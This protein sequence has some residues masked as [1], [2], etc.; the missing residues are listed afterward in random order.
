MDIYFI[1]RER[2]GV[3]V[4]YG[5]REGLHPFLRPQIELG[6]GVAY[7]LITNVGHESR[8][9]YGCLISGKRSPASKH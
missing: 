5:I 2:L 3:D 9:G 4:D 8:P 6:S 1:L 7:K